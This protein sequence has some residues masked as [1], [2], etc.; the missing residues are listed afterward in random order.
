MTHS[1]FGHRVRG[2][3][4]VEMMVALVL[5]LVVVGAVMQVFLANR[6]TYNISDGMVRAQESARYAMLRINQDLRMAGAG[7]MCSG[8]PVQL[9]S[10]LRP[11]N[12]GDGDVEDIV[13]SGGFVVFDYNGTG[14]NTDFPFPAYAMGANGQWGRFGAANGLPPALQGRVLAGTDVIGLRTI[15]PVSAELTGCTNNQGTSNQLGVCDENNS[16]TNHGMDQ[17]T[18]IAAVDCSAGVGDI[19]MST[20]NS[21]ANTFARGGPGIAGVRNQTGGARWSTAYRENTEF[22][23]TDVTYYFIGASAG[24]PPG[25]I[26][27][28][29]FRVSNCNTQANCIYEELA[30][31]VENL[32]VS[33]RV[34]GN[35]SLLDPR[36]ANIGNWANVTALELDLVLVSPN[37][38][39]TRDL[40]QSLDLSNDLTVTMTDRRIRLVY[41][42]TVAVR[43]RITVR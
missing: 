5:G 4:L 28:A 11:E 34:N 9:N 8:A 25:E 13:T 10:L 43:N 39:D 3:S 36:D 26:R 32:Q 1:F 40:A 30:D 23:R 41:S 24:S 2:F 35:D 38:V 33:V 37:E 31:G 20:N 21:N 6:I 27:P 17:G 29:L 42:N 14:G 18:I 15:Q 12:N 22:Y 16:S 19:F 7:P